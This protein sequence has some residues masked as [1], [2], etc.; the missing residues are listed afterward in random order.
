MKG[1]L[2]LQVLHRRLRELDVV[3]TVSH[4]WREYLEGIGCRKVRVI[5]NGFDLHEYNISESQIAHFRH[6]YK[7][8]SRRPLIYIGYT[9]GDKGIFDVYEILKDAGYTLVMT[10]PTADRPAIPIMHLLLDRQDYLCL[11]SACDIVLSMSQIEEGWSRISHEALLCGTPVIG[12]GSGG[13]QELLDGAN[14][15]TCR[16]IKDL[17]VLVNEVLS[18]RHDIV[19]R[20]TAFVRQFDLPSFFRQWQGLFKELLGE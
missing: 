8:P 16:N 15:L 20:G 19:S 10:G 17:P 5:H 1:K 13:M 11:L 18:K 14:Q 3:V 4:Y 2:S 7:L 6:R 9:R 12:S